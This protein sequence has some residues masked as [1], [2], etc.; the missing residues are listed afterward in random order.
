M[1]RGSPTAPKGLSIWQAVD[2]G[3]IASG[4]TRWYRTRVEEHDPA[5]GEL[6]VG[7]PMIQLS[8]VSV[9]RGDLVYLGAPIASDALYVVECLVMQATLEPQ[10]RLRLRPAGEWHR[11]QRREHVRIEVSI[12]P[13]SVHLLVSEGEPEPLSARILDLSAGGARLRLGKPLRVG[14][15]LA[16]AFTVPGCPGPISTRAEV[17]RC[18]PIEHADPPRWDAGCRFENLGQRE[19]D[20]LVRFIFTR[21]RELARQ[22]RG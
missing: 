3:V 16:L 1:S 5:T 21:Q 20:Q 19:T 6:T 8:Y 17:R 15:R 18:W 9:H 13:E 11:M 10:A 2:L 22:L 12:V 4:E 7:W 14:D